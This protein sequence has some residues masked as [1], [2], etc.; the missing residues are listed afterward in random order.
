[1]CKVNNMDANCLGLIAEPSV[2]KKTVEYT[3][4]KYDAFLISLMIEHDSDL[5]KF[6]KA[7]KHDYVDFEIDNET[8]HAQYLYAD[9]REVYFYGQQHH[10]HAEML[11]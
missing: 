1:M 8:Y 5:D 6:L 4:T 11:N 7:K 10:A 2:V 3:E 9:G